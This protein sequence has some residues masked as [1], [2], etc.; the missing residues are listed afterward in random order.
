MIFTNPFVL[1]LL[2][3]ALLP[4]FLERTH[5]RNYSWVDMLP[6]D[7][8]SN[9]VALFLKLLAVIALLFVLL[10][11]AGPQTPEQQI[12][13]IGIGAQI[14][15]VLDRSASMD[16]AFSGAGQSG[17]VGETKSAAASRLI[18]DFINK[19]KNDMIGLITFSNSAMHVLPLTDNREAVLAAVRA[20]ARVAASAPDDVRTAAPSGAAAQSTRA[21]KHPQARVHTCWKAVSHTR[22]S[23]E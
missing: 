13:K 2:P 19:R 22:G 17:K 4:L 6:A 9:I 15:L 21:P 3:L 1:W 18:T 8:L 11:L 7:P 12:E 16:D 5:S 20:T 23:L 14:A 10:G